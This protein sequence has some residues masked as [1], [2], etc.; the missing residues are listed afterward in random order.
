MRMDYVAFEQRIGEHLAEVSGNRI[1]P[2]IQE[3]VGCASDEAKPQ[4]PDFLYPALGTRN[5]RLNF[6]GV[7]TLRTR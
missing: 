4:R 6:V 7:G 3:D 2:A 5:R 1:F